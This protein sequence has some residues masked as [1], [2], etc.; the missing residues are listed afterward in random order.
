MFHIGVEIPPEARHILKVVLGLCKI[1]TKLAIRNLV[2]PILLKLIRILPPLIQMTNLHYIKVDHWITKI[3]H[4]FIQIIIHPTKFHLPTRMLLPT[5]ITCSRAIAN[6]LL[7]FESKL[8]HIKIPTQT[9][10]LQCQ[11]TRQTHILEIK[12]TLRTIEVIN[13]RLPQ[14][15]DMIPLDLCSTRKVWGIS[16][17]SQ[18]A[19]LSCTS[20]WLLLDISTQF[21][22]NPWI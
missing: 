2:I 12:L 16:P 11:T 17:R 1:H 3:H 7:C 19:E 15:E 21:Y 4:P 14:K 9:T 13:I 22:Q 8:H 18:K 5:V 6:L 10:K 20:D